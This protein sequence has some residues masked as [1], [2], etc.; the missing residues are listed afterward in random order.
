MDHAIDERIAQL[1]QAIAAQ[2]SLRP[3]LGD[4]IVDATITVL[5]KEL[6]TL[7][8]Q[9]AV[10]Q[11]KQVTV[12]FADLVGFVHMSESMD[13][14]DVRDV[15]NAYF[16]R[17][18]AAI[19]RFGGV[20]E[21]FIGDAVMAV[22][23]IPTA[24]ESD[25]EH[26][27]RAALQMQRALAE[28][29]E[30][31]ARQ[32]SDTT[33]CLSMRVGISTGSVVVTFSPP[34]PQTAVP[35]LGML[36]QGENFAIV[37][38]VVNLASRL[39]KVCPANGIL[40]SHEAYR[41]VRGLF[42]IR[43]LEPM[44]IKG[45]AEPV[46]V[47]NILRD[48]PR[49]FRLT[50]RGV[51]GIETRMVGRALEL[52]EMQQA[53]RQV[54]EYRQMRAVTVVGEAG[55]GKS[56]LLY[57]FRS[58]VQLQPESIRIFKG[59]ADQ[60]MRKLPY[61]LIRDLF[62]FRFEIQDNDP[63]AVA[64]DKLIQGLARF[65][66]EDAASKGPFI[67]H[68]IGLDFSS[69]PYLQGILNDSRQI[70]D[71]ALYYMAQF[72]EAVAEGAQVAFYL[73][74]IHWTDDGSLEA[75]EYL[76][77]ECAHLPVLLLCLT[78]P[79]FFERVPQWGEARPFHTRLNLRPLSRPESRLLIEEILCR[80]P[81]V[82]PLLQELVVNGAEGNPFYS[83]EIIKML[84]EDGVIVKG[85][86]V[87]QV[88]LER[89]AEVRVPPTLTGVLQARLDG[90]T[91]VEREVLQCA[92]VIGR[93][94]WEDAVAY[95][96]AAGHAGAG[97]AV[98]SHLVVETKSALRALQEKELVF[99]KD[100][101]AFT[102]TVEYI[103]KQAVLRDV[104]YNSV[105]KRQRRLYHA[106]LAA[107]LVDRSGERVNQYAGLIGEHFEWAGE[108]RLAAEWYGRAGKQA[109]DTYAPGSAL[110]YYQKALALISTAGTV[111][112]LQVSLRWR[113]ILY[114]GLG[115]T[116]YRQAKASEAI[117]SFEAMQRGAASLPDSLS[118]ARA[119][120]GLARVRTFQG[121]YRATLHCASQAEEA[122]RKAG[123]PTQPEL[124]AVLNVKVFAYYRLGDFEAAL[125][126]GNQ[127]LELATEVG[128]KREIARSFNLIG[129]VHT[130]LGSFGKVDDCYE[131]AL[132]LYQEVG[133]R[134]GV[135]S[136]FNNL[137]ESARLR[138]DYGAAV[139]LYQDALAI[140]REIGEHDGEA[141]ALMNLAGARVGLG[142]YETAEQDLRQVLRIVESANWHGL[143]ET[144]RFLAEACLGQ[145]RL[146]QAFQAAHRALTLG[147]EVEEQELIGR[148]WY[149][150]GK[151]AA[152]LDRSLALDIWGNGA[153]AL[154][155]DAAACFAEAWHVFN[156][157]RMEA[158]QARTLRTWAVYQREHDEPVQADEM[159]QEA[160][161]IFSRLGMVLEVSRMDEGEW[162]G[163][164]MK[165]EG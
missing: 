74:D 79:S 91:A 85:Q 116:L 157:T 71:R 30:E 48:N 122:A 18:T 117:Q 82:P 153:P 95:L 93:N 96:R 17:W 7:E 19:T 86:E 40:I 160:R 108:K 22:F 76:M 164:G 25:P 75:I 36:G 97:K 154:E 44:A 32:K 128:D 46:P 69:S 77:R 137:G 31:M 132:A 109:L 23:G 49:A 72:F 57:E 28:L 15:M 11:R 136:V 105:L 55:I 39:E 9:S 21:K 129:N 158:D 37:G 10:E 60:G 126:L 94:F 78:R 45:K 63:A 159:W 118:E 29:N 47:Y 121:D 163:G 65:M 139:K 67:G 51:E 103:F 13:P 83:E 35:A 147:R 34:S 127:A 135:S 33:L 89:L 50:S 142:L 125:N 144:Y 155:F 56:R 54:I 53:L 104:T 24:R 99:L 141:I 112:D 134:S 2:E 58:W 73:E 1:R 70:R 156:E 42:S 38:D 41:H 5:N 107:W 88:Q 161:H 162:G 62:A 68:L 145:T 87:W 81:D 131:Q 102:G 59:R 114:E 123:P 8:A 148:A 120:L 115:E 133:D 101:S 16:Q 152:H 151:I 110:S 6:A 92:S 43:A 61:A 84:I 12:L 146:D 3:L 66:G 138:G 98:A 113:V 4:A 27:I 140:T 119:W 20:V 150:L 90:L 165:E 106:Q 143:S 26:A 149:V 130:I 14:E 80:V 52:Q 100:G 111:P 124:V 64:R